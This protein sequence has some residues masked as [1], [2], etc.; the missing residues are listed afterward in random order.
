MRMVGPAAS[1]DAAF[2][3]S[4]TRR[5]NAIHSHGAAR[6]CYDGGLYRGRG[7]GRGYVGRRVAARIA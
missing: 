4:R 6:E 5:S 7:T 2:R 3:V 1:T